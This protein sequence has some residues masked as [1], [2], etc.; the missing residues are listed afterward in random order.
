[1]NDLAIDETPN[2]GADPAVAPET[3]AAATGGG[4]PAVTL[5]DWPAQ[6]AKWAGEDQQKLD[7]LA[8]YP[9]REAAL[10]ALIAA[11]D[12]IRSGE[13]RKPLSD[14]PTPE[15]LHEYRQNHGIP[16]SADKYDLADIG[17]QAT[18]DESA[19]LQQFLEI[20]HNANMTPGM[21][22]ATVAWVNDRAKAEERAKQD[23]IGAAKAQAE[24]VLRE[25]WG[26]DYRVNQNVIANL[27]SSAPEGVA[28]KILG[29]MDSDGIPLA[30]K[31]EVQEWLAGL[32]REINPVSTIIPANGAATVSDELANLTKLAGDLN[33]EYWVGPKAQDLQKRRQLLAG[34]SRAR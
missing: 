25:R 3:V 1:M 15:E 17:I 12:K 7:R 18:P 6:R 33:S 34:T 32:A 31:P 13:H 24:D 16:I 19:D 28:D 23:A 22:K 27:L 10:D 20:A 30:Y 26:S 9:S 4:A 14:D 11:Q 29:A 2:D 8:R 5:D 21:L